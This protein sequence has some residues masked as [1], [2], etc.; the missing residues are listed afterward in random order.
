MTKAVYLG[1]EEKLQHKTHVNLR[2]VAFPQVPRV[3]QMLFID[4]VSCPDQ[5]NLHIVKFQLLMNRT[6]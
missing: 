4:D 6:I 5:T 1:Y 2:R 3:P